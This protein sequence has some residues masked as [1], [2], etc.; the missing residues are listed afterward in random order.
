MTIAKG[1]FK[2][3]SLIEVINFAL[4]NDYEILEGAF[5]GMPNLKTV[6]FN[7]KPMIIKVR[8]FTFSSINEVSILGATAIEDEAFKGCIKFQS[9]EF[10]A[11]LKTIGNETFR[12]CITLSKTKNS[13][14]NNLFVVPTGVNLVC[15]RAFYNCTSL[16]IVSYCNIINP[17]I[18]QYTGQ[19]DECAKTSMCLFLSTTQVMSS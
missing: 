10:G 5:N 1:G 13:G 8:T 2:G 17:T 19:F 9:I 7:E 4:L 6:K 11:N 15:S 14:S 16:K 3:E 12:D 18:A